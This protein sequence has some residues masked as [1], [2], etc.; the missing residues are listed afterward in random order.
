[1]ARADTAPLLDTAE[2]MR[3]ADEFA[4][5]IVALARDARP[6]R[7]VSFVARRLPAEAGEHAAWFAQ[8][9][10]APLS[11]TVVGTYADLV[12]QVRGDAVQHDL[13]V[14]LQISL[15][16][17]RAE[18]RALQR[19]GASREDAAA[20]LVCEEL[21][22]LAAA[23]DACGCRV[24]GA[25]QPSLL[26][27]ALRS[28]VDPATPER[29]S[30]HPHRD[31]RDAGMTSIAAGPGIL[32]EGWSQRAKRG[33]LGAHALGRKPAGDSR[34]GIPGTAARGGRGCAQR[35]AH[36][37]AAGTEARNAPGTSDGAGCRGRRRAARAARHPRHRPRPPSPPGGASVGSRACRRTRALPPRHLRDR[38]RRLARGARRSNGA[39]RARCARAPASSCAC[40]RASRHA[41][42]ASRC[43]ASAEASCEALPPPPR[44]PRPRRSDSRI[45]SSAARDWGSAGSSSAPIRRAGWSAS[46]PSS[47]TPAARSQARASRSWARSAEANRASSRSLVLR[48]VGTLGRRAVIISPKRGEYDALAAA[49]GTTTIRLGGNSDAR[50][51]PLDAPGLTSRLRA[52][53]SGR[54]RRACARARAGRG[55][56][57]RRRPHLP[58]RRRDAAGAC[59]VA[60]LAAR[61]RCCVRAGVTRSS[62]RRRRASSRSASTA[63]RA[64]TPPA[65]STRQR[66]ASRSTRP[67][68]CSI[69]QRWLSAPRHRS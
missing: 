55:R 18:M 19:S 69:S 2:A 23:L 67:W 50:L 35:G 11:A 56:C 1:M 12:E 29:L 44:R 30:P 38:A 8:R 52:A 51:N 43:P 36:A 49:L 21:R 6:V 60:A 13:A 25:L 24:A 61:A 10:A 46:T 47:S 31:N 48:Q 7:R 40:W 45:P 42:S 34:G 15:R 64:A 54:A 26:C 3:R 20:R 62:G 37:R 39:S 65:C 5:L 59:R 41:R 14:T 63:S 4:A 22:W 32:E 66:A 57:A 53:R 17:R 68:S 16:A 33:R 9:R 27:E 58:G 28:G